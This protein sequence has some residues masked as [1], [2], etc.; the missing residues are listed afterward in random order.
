[1]INKLVDE[2]LITC[3]RC[4]LF[5]ATNRLKKYRMHPLIALAVRRLTKVIN[6]KRND[7]EIIEASLG[8]YYN[9]IHLKYIEIN[10]FLN[11]CKN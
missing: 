2:F 8:V 6:E 11:Y 10:H 4:C 9:F 5:Y 7:F 1:M 3:A